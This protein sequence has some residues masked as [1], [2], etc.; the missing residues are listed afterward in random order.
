MIIDDLNDLYDALSQLDQDPALGEGIARVGMEKANVPYGL[1]IDGEGN[2]V[3]ISYFVDS[4][5]GRNVMQVPQHAPRSRNIAGNPLWDNATYLLG[6]MISKPNQAAACF[7][8]AAEVNK[9]IFGGIDS[10]AAKAIVAFF[11]RPPQWEKAQEFVGEDAW[12]S[13]SKSNFIFEYNGVVLNKD[14]AIMNACL[15]TGQG[16]DTG[17]MT[18]QS[19][20]SG[21]QV[22]PARLHPKIKG[23]MGAQSSGAN[24]VSYNFPAAESYGHDQ[25]ANAPLSDEEAFKYGTTLNHLLADNDRRVRVGDITVVSWARNGKTGY[26]DILDAFAMLDGDA[27]ANRDLESIVIPAVRKILKGEQVSFEGMDLHPDEHYCILGLAPNAARLAVSFYL[28]DTFQKFLGNVDNHYKDIQI[29][30][31]P[32]DQYT[33]PPLWMLLRATVNQKSKS[34]NAS[35]ELTGAMLRSVLMDLPYPV[36]LLNAVSIRIRA[37]H[38]ITSNQ[39]AIIKGYYA[40]LSR[41]GRTIIPN[42][43][44]ADKQFKEVLRMSINNESEYVP[45]VLGRMFSL[46]EQIQRKANPKIGTTIKDRYF[47]SACATPALIFPVLGDLSQAHL[48][49]LKRTNP[50]AMVNL[51]RALETLAVRVGERYPD[52]LTI[53]EQGAFQLGYYFEDRASYDNHKTDRK[54]SDK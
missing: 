25:G 47:N 17:Q 29:D 1:Q 49:K 46:Y 45:Y 13:M 22:V 10:P 24:L 36:T 27:N 34:K 4:P 8:A 11:S 53:Q 37:E 15:H 20:V 32:F 51:T 50:G 54:D 35:D 43:S 21:K 14:E 44:A 9:H 52:R 3:G 38:G 42:N 6:D 28:K 19:L 16:H 48:R 33:R 31:P 40:R 23:V 5:K 12:K 26:Q 41:Q 39:A 18:M 7:A 2:L 30:R